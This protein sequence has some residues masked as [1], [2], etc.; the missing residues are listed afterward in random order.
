MVLQRSSVAAVSINDVLVKET[1]KTTTSAIY[2]TAGNSSQ[3][4]R[5]MANA[6]IY[7]CHERIG[8]F[9]QSR[10]IQKQQ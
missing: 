2:Y 10:P 7:H 5:P 6:Y 3:H 8:L 4:F 9:A 1:L